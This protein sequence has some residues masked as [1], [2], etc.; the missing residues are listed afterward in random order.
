LFFRFFF[1]EFGAAD[2]GIGFRFF[3]RLFVLGFDETRGES[4]DLIFVQFGVIP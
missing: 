4:G 2:D 1:I 3:L